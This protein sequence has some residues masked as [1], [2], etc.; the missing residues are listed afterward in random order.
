FNVEQLHRLGTHIP[1]LRRRVDDVGHLLEAATAI[2]GMVL[3]ALV[4]RGAR[5][6]ARLLEERRHDAEERAAAATLFSAKLESIARATV[7]IAA[8]ITRSNRLQDVFLAIARQAQAVTGA[9]F[10]ALG[11]GTDPTCPF[12][13]WTFAG[14]SEEEAQAIGRTPRPVGLL[15]AVA[16]QGH[17]IRVADV[18]K[19][20][21]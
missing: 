8:A 4:V 18:R 14:M 17:P 9:A 3:M 2:S 5:R 12:D 15:G 20:P 6:Y 19:H 1:N 16:Q 10:C 13:P 21:A 11:F 7:G